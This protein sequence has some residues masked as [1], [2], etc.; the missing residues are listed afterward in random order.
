[1]ATFFISIQVVSFSAPLSNE[2]LSSTTLPI[3]VQYVRDMSFSPPLDEQVSDSVLPQMSSL[4]AAFFQLIGP[5]FVLSWI[6][7]NP[8]SLLR[9]FQLPLALL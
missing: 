2:Q 5:T 9:I 3:D 8:L 1:M 6:I 7:T 4:V